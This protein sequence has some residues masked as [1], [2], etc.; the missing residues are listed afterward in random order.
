MPKKAMNYFLPFLALGCFGFTLG[1]RPTFASRINSVVPIG[2]KARLVIGFMP[3]LCMRASTALNSSFNSTIISSMVS[4]I[5]FIL[6]SVFHKILNIARKILQYTKQGYRENRKKIKKN[7]KIPTKTLDK[8]RK[9]PIIKDIGQAI[10]LAGR[11]KQPAL[12]KKMAAGSPGSQRS[13]EWKN[14]LQ[15]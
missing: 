7:R 3:A 2:Y 6:S 9:Y 11:E 8:C 12:L 5:I 15:T 14:K 1:G 4:P 13:F 10:V